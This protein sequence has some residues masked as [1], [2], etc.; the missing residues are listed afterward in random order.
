MWEQIVNLA[1]QNGL[2]AVLFLGLLIYELKDSS[3]R[4]K[5]YQETIEKMNKHIDVVEDIEKDVCEIEK[6]VEDIKISVNGSKNRAKNK[7]KAV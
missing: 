2:F 5:K 1:I 6:N 7:N 3:K 4:E